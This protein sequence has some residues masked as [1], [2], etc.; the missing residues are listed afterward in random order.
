MIQFFFV[1]YVMIV[2]K[3]SSGFHLICFYWTCSEASR[4]YMWLYNNFIRHHVFDDYILRYACYNSR[5]GVVMTT[6]L[7]CGLLL[8]REREFVLARLFCLRWKRSPKCFSYNQSMLSDDKEFTTLL[9]LGGTRLL[10]SINRMTTDLNVVP[11][12]ADVCCHFR[13][14]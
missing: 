12:H 4:K 1:M 2:G 7:Y 9:Q 10:L 6:C 3:K 11:R 13:L 8:V 5:F 14:G